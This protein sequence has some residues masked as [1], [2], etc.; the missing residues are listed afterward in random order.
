MR[1]EMLKGNQ[2]ALLH[3]VMWSL[4]PVIGA[5][6]IAA[7]PPIPGLA[8]ITG[9]MLIFFLGYAAYTGTLFSFRLSRGLMDAIITALLI[10]TAFSLFFVGLQYT[11]AGNA[12][13]ISQ[14]E[15][16]FSFFVFNLIR[17]E[18]FTTADLIG[19]MLMIS[20]GML[21][22]LPDVLEHATVNRGDV[23]ILCATAIAPVLNFFQ[24][25]AR[26][27]MSNE[28]ILLVRSAVGF[29]F[30]LTLAYLFGQST[31]FNALWSVLP[32]LIFGGVVV[33]GLSK[34]FWLEAMRR[35]SM[36]KANAFNATS[37]VATLLFAFVI[38]GE[39][40]TV[41]QLVSLIP[42]LAGAYILMFSHKT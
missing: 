39:T 16:F 29:P 1:G 34:V 38:L 37:P 33:F 22:F 15:F 30:L 23:L 27:T 12:G 6:T 18:S 24:R 2:F 26:E 5:L 21:I 4:A 20:G 3:A 32:I 31:T 7:M 9:V 28:M 10:A 19:G 36:V 40:P 17:R 25:R 41:F 42:L 8:A 14:F 11:T 35:I 13:I